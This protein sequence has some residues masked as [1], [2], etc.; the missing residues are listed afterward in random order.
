METSVWLE[1]QKWLAPPQYGQ[2]LQ[3]DVVCFTYHDLVLAT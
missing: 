2:R 3:A 1:M